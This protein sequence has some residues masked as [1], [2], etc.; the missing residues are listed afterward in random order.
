MFLL[1]WDEGGDAWRWQ[2]HLWVWEEELLGE[3]MTLLHDII[4]QTHSSD[5][6]QWPLD[7]V[8]GYS[9]RDV[10]QLLT[11]REDVTLNAAED[12]A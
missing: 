12:F 11:T 5:K 10:Y 6:W 2:R 8:R 7:P 4:L 1:G 3:C 9:V